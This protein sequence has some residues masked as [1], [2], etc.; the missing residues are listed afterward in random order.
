M[1][2]AKEY[3]GSQGRTWMRKSMK[4]SWLYLHKKVVKMADWWKL[5]ELQGTRHHFLLSLQMLVHREALTLICP[6]WAVCS[7]HYELLNSPAGLRPQSTAL[8]TS[9]YTSSL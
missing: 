8:A 3:M 2:P 9:L 5:D 6:M 4:F 7:V 1:L